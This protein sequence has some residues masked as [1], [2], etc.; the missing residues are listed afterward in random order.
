MGDLETIPLS[1]TSDMARRLEECAK[2][3]NLSVPELVRANVEDW[4]AID[5]PESKGR[6]TRR[7]I[8]RDGPL[9]LDPKLIEEIEGVDLMASG[10]GT[11]SGTEGAGAE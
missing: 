7:G 2:W 1:L 6:L 4:I 3:R 9:A 10:V 5:Y 11:S 8:H